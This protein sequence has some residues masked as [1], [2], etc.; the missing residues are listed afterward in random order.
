MLAVHEID[1]GVME[2]C[3]RLTNRRQQ[4]RELAL[5]REGYRIFGVPDKYFE[6][7]EYWRRFT[8]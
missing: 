5:M 3:V 2:V 1:L 7:A 6:A 8:P 4:K